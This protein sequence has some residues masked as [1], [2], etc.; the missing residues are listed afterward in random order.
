MNGIRMEDG[1]IFHRRGDTGVIRVR[2]RLYENAP[3]FR[4]REGDKAI[5]TIKKRMHDQPYVLQ[6]ETDNGYFAML[7]EDTAKLPFGVYWYDMVR[8]SKLTIQQNL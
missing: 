5:L 1:K 7:H 4:F 2:M 6:K 3:P 8:V